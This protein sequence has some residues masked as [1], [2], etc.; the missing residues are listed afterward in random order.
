MNICVYTIVFN[1]Y[2]RFVSTWLSNIE[3]QT[4][5][6]EEV[7]IVLGKDHG[8]DIDSL[9]EYVK[10][11]T[12]N[13]KVMGSLR[14]KAIHKAS[15]DWMLYFSVDDELKSNAIEEIQKKSDS[16]D[17]I[18]LRFLE[19]SVKDTDEASIERVG[20]CFTKDNMH[21][22][23]RIGVPGYIAHKR[24]LNKRIMYYEKIDIPNF[25]FLFL[26]AI[27]DAKCNP[28]DNVCA[29]YIRW[30]GSHGDIAF[31]TRKYLDYGDIIDKLLDEKYL[32]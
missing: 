9:P 17:A 15:A 4:V 6:P 2:G 13:D 31:K 7:I 32:V 1:N 18:P 3:K 19:R 21:L 27:N 16:S 11:I 10:V 20:G 22:W 26:L 23:K 14:N 8:V 29:T 24:K 5:K 25:P 28:T 12:T 30:K